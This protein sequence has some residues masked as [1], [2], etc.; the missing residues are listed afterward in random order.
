[1]QYFQYNVV[2]NNIQQQYNGC[3]CNIGN[4]HKAIG[5]V[6]VQ[7]YFT[8]D[9]FWSSNYFDNSTNI[10][11]VA[12]Y[13]LMMGSFA[14][15]GDLYGN[16]HPVTSSLGFSIFDE[17]GNATITIPATPSTTAL[18][19]NTEYFFKNT[20]QEKQYFSCIT[21]SQGYFAAKGRIINFETST[22]NSTQSTK[23]VATSDNAPRPI[24]PTKP[25]YYMLSV[26]GTQAHIRSQPSGIDCQYGT[27][28]C[29]ALFNRGSEVELELVGIKT[30]QGFSQQDYDV[31]W[32]GKDCI[33]QRLIMDNS[34][35][36][37]VRVYGKQGIDYSQQP[38]SIP[39]Q[40]VDLRFI[41]FS[42]Y[43]ILGGTSEDIFLGFILEGDGAANVKLQAHSLDKGVVPQ[44]DLHQLTVNSTG[45]DSTLLTRQQQAHEFSFEHM[46]DEGIYTVQV[47]SAGVKE[48][49][50]AGITLNNRELNLT[51]LSVRGRLQDVLIL[52]FIVEG[53]HTHKIKVNEYIL[54]GQMDT[55]LQLVN[56]STKQF[57]SLTE[58][59]IIEVS[60]GAYAIVL[61]AVEGEGIGMIDIDLL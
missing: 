8:Y 41:N 26:A 23:Q 51:N 60:A 18:A 58:Q 24:A 12:G 53:K 13:D 40:I 15:G 39:T 59:D 6:L 5:Y 44:L 54:E 31:V 27:G 43:G 35:Q 17:L 16:I 47:S 10:S 52:N 2:N 3:Y 61:K 34:K 36:C 20:S 50:M 45:V 1:M 21:D 11:A 22:N 25:D 30:A 28:S 29:K 48:R 56:L 38:D 32:E 46:V 7:N 33:S 37:L 4:S 19:P 9:D 14:Y 57:H 49:G 42:G 55:E